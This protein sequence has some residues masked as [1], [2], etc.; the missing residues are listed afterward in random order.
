MAQ[1]IPFVAAIEIEAVGLVPS[2]QSP[3]RNSKFSIGAAEKKG[4]NK[5]MG[6]HYI[7]FY[8]FLC[9]TENS[10]NRRLTKIF[11]KASTKENGYVPYILAKYWVL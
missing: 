9:M 10:H 2:Q 5:K 6:V 7:P 1:T 11:K 3:R 8:L 4:D